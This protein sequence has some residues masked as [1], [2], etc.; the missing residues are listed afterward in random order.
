MIKGINHVAI[1]VPDLEEGQ[2]FWVEALGLPID[3]IAHVPAEGVEVA[4]LAAGDV[5]IELLQPLDEES[6]V[7]KFLQKRGPGIHHIC[8]EVADIAE[9][10]GRL[11]DAGIQLLNETPRTN[12]DGRQYAFI[13]PKSAGGV[14]VELYQIPVPQPAG[15]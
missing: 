1:V 6:G 11:R 4:F 15:P 12:P 3:H 8:L 10:M 7:A 13:H 14:L 2:R 9:M 5:E